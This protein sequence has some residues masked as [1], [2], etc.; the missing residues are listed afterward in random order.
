MQ[1]INKTPISKTEAP[2]WK[3]PAEGAAV[4]SP[5][6]YPPRLMPESQHR[7]GCQPCSPISEDRTKVSRLRCHA[8]V[9]SPVVSSLFNV[10]RF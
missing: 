5:G 2:F 4:H 3:A 7:S 6:P 10:Y 8:C 9:S 1:Q